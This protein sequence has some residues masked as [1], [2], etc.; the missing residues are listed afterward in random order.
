MIGIDVYS[1]EQIDVQ[2]HKN[3]GSNTMT[4]N[5]SKDTSN[6]R[7]NKA[8][9]PALSVRRSGESMGFGGFNMKGSPP[10]SC[11]AGLV[12]VDVVSLLREVTDTLEGGSLTEEGRPVKNMSHRQLLIYFLLLVD[13]KLA[14]SLCQLF[15]ARMSTL[16][17]G[18]QQQGQL[19]PY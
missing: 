4:V 15:P 13:M 19:S 8:A 9:K 7:K 1:N 3:N 17:P 16:I 10:G 2:P 6:K 14:A 12:P 11:V 18:P 5:N